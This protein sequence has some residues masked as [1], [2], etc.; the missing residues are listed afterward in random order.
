[1]SARVTDN[2]HRPGKR[3]RAGDA[4]PPAG[5]ESRVRGQGPRGQ[6]RDRP[7]DRRRGRR[8]T[9]SGGGHHR[10]AAAVG[11]ARGGRAADGPRRHPGQ[12]RRPDRDHVHGRPG[13]RRH[14]RGH[15]QHQLPGTTLGMNG[16]CA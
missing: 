11:D 1:M 4:V 15:S 7:P 2:G 5:R 9:R 16:A 6:R 10:Q 14:D 3:P 8:G 13:C 12:Q